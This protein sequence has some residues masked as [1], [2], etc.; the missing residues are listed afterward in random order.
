MYCINYLAASDLL[1][2]VMK[3]DAHVLARV[4][5]ILE[6]NELLMFH[7]KPVQRLLKYH[8]L[9]EVSPVIDSLSPR[10]SECMQTGGR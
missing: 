1:Q 7:I 10:L 6:P 3:S 2:N 4:S 5:H 8:L 9:F